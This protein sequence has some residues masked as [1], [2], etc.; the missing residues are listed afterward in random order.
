M[1]CPITLF[2]NL[3]PFTDNGLGL[4]IHLSPRVGFRSVKSAVTSVAEQS[5]RRLDDLNRFCRTI[6]GL[7]LTVQCNRAM[8]NFSKVA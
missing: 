3:A 4:G 7:T 8:C 1:K 5:E 2:V 6:E